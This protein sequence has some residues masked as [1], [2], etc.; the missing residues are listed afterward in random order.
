MTVCN[1]T[2][3]NREFLQQTHDDIGEYR[4]QILIISEMIEVLHIMMKIDYAVKVLPHIAVLY[5]Y[6]RGEH[7]KN[8]HKYRSL[9]NN[10]SADC[11]YDAFNF[12]STGQNIIVFTELKLFC[13]VPLE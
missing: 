9:S 1:I 12:I 2:N 10:N 13:S 6:D 8:L 4:L 11:L 5:F 7:L 3:A